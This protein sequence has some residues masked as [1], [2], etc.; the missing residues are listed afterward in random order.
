[1]K[2]RQKAH[3]KPV[4]I[5]LDK[6]RKDESP[7]KKPASEPKPSGL[8]LNGLSVD[9]AT[10]E[11]EPQI[12]ISTCHEL[13]SCASALRIL[14]VNLGPSS[15][16]SNDDLELSRNLVLNSSLESLSIQTSINPK[17]LLT[18]LRLPSLRHF[19][20]NVLDGEFARH[21]Y[22]GIY[23]LLKHSECSLTTLQ[24][25]DVYPRY[26]ELDR[27]LRQQ[28]CHTLQQL[29]VRS[30]LPPQVITPYYRRFITATALKA[31]AQKT[32]TGLVL[33]P[34]LTHLELSHLDY[35]CESSSE[36][37]LVEMVKARIGNGQPF[38]LEYTLRERGSHA[39]SVA[40]KLGVLAI[41]HPLTFS[42]THGQWIVNLV[43]LL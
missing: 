19:R 26:G 14:V 43:I 9:F 2:D 41:T 34:R 39:D 20:L 5:V 30:M 33:C 24:L 25:I 10:T 15:S 3:V 27:C 16:S 22:L 1:M 21:G 4:K 32:N 36:D 13:I 38:H 29:I 31:F 6:N 23:K 28:A 40:K 7:S 35:L 17:P 42:G 18:T 11:V 12:S 8:V 37:L